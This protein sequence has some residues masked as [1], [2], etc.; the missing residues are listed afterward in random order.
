MNQKRF[1][2]KWDTYTDH[3]REM[4][5]DM[6][7][8]NELSDVTLVSD[9]K[10]HFKAHKV[11][12]C[13]SSPIFRSII[14]DS[15]LSNTNPILYLRGIQSHEI[16]SI[17]QFIY[18][19][20]TTFFKDKMDDFLNV[21][22]SLEIKEIGYDNPKNEE[23]EKEEEFGLTPN[24]STF[25]SELEQINEARAINEKQM[26]SPTR[27]HN[28]VYTCEICSKQY[29]S[30]HGLF[31]HIRSIHEGV[32]FA[33]DQCSHIFASSS[34]LS[35]HVKSIHEAF[36]YQCDMCTKQYNN[37]SALLQHK[38]SVHDGITYPCDKCNHVAAYP[39]SLRSHV[40]TVHEAFR[41]HCDQCN[42]EF[43]QKGKLQ[44]HIESVHQGV[45]YPCDQCSSKFSQKPHLLRHI[46][47]THD[48]PTI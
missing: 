31:L 32:K 38:K 29:S 23:I 16:E 19:G 43:T 41:Y 46:K 14:I 11:V 48:I 30:Y 21:A 4:L 44:Q 7:A 45:K 1:T 6:M 15:S 27:S 28:S 17:L 35:Q 34:G 12:L 39:N 47:L 26:Q 9:D 8:S 18:L 20:Q 13:A 3:L 37:N 10:K 25:N 22:K 42:S 40:K 2:L 24:L 33:C 36:K 5:Q